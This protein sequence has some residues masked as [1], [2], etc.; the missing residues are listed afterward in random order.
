M[1]KPIKLKCKKKD[2]LN[3]WIYKGDSKFYAPCSKCKGSVNVKKARE[4]QKE[5]G[6]K[7]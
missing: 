3:E 4:E 1:G 7:E 2:C 5:K 6:G